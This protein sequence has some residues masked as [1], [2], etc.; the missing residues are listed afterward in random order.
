MAAGHLPDF[1]NIICNISNIGLY[2]GFSPAKSLVT[3]SLLKTLM[4]NFSIIAG[5]FEIT[6]NQCQT[7]QPDYP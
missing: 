4:H 5:S 6:G 7:A 3:P 2:A 1:I